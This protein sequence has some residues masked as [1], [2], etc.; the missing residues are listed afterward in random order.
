MAP[1]Y[2]FGSRRLKKFVLFVISIV[3]SQGDLDPSTIL[4]NILR[5]V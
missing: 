4:P 5:Y 2:F 3:L 1:V